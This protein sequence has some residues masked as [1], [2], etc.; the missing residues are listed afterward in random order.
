MRK[1]YSMVLSVVLVFVFSMP[2]QSQVTGCLENENSIQN[3]H[4]SP[5]FQF[6]IQGNFNKK[7]GYFG[8][9][10]VTK[11]WSEIYPGLSWQPTSWLQ[12]GIGAGIEQ[13]QS[14]ARIGEFIW[15][16][17]GK[18]YFLGFTEHSGSGFWYRAMAMY[19]ASQRLQVGLMSQY[20]LGI[21][22]KVEMV[23]HKPFSLWVAVLMLGQDPRTT[24]F[25]GLK[26]GF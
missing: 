3:G 24:V 13:N 22:P 20:R 15:I 5:G 23:I 14:K 21:G 8:W 1:F 16:G 7:F 18:F 9:A 4:L 2:A 12:V 17:K 19:Q 6:W 25:T 10:L 26:L 11:N